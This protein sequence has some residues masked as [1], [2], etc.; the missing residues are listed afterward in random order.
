MGLI[1]KKDNEVH[2]SWCQCKACRDLGAALDSKK[3]KG[4]G[5]GKGK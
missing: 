1:F 3:G 5:S 2:D 4:K